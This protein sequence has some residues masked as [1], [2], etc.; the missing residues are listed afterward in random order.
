MI[1]TRINTGE[2]E[3]QPEN[4]NRYPQLTTEEQLDLAVKTINNMMSYF[5]GACGS[6]NV[7]KPFAEHVLKAADL[8]GAYSGEVEGAP[9]QWL[10]D[11]WFKTQ[12]Q[13]PEYKMSWPVVPEYVSD[14]VPYD[15]MNPDTW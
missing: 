12:K 14:A 15:P 5:L 11:E 8:L 13:F 2:K 1:H 9:G 6:K 4:D 7:I 10:R 3:M